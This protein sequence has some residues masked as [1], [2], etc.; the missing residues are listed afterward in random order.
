MIDEFIEKTLTVASFNLLDHYLHTIMYHLDA[1]NG[2]FGC[3]T[4]VLILSSTLIPCSLLG[5]QLLLGVLYSVLDSC[6]V[7]F[8]ECSTPGLCS[9]LGAPLLFRFL[10]LVLDTCFVFFNGCSILRFVLFTSCSTLV[11]SSLDTFNEFLHILDAVF[12]Y[13][14]ILSVPGSR[15]VLLKLNQFL[16]ILLN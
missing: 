13:S 6:F 5:A 8:N 16:G 4:L 9:L 12:R 15:S 7:L 1:C 10:Y 3:S 2:W 14:D 11:S